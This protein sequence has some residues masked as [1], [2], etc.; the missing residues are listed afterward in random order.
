MSFGNANIG[1]SVNLA[2]T[3]ASDGTDADTVTGGVQANTDSFAN[4]DEVQGSAF[5]DT[6]VGGGQSKSFSGQLSETFRG[7]AGNDSVDGSAGED[8]VDYR[9]STGAANVTLGNGTLGGSA[10]D[11]QGGTDTL[12]NVEAVRG[13]AF[14]DTLTGGGTHNTGT[15]YDYEVFEGME[16]NDII[17]GG[18]GFDI[19]VYGASDGGVIVNLSNLDQTVG[20]LIVQAGTALDGFGTKDTLLGVEQVIGSDYA[21]TIF[22]SNSLTDR[23]AFRGGAGNDLIFGGGGNDGAFYNGSPNAVYVNLG[24][25]FANDG[26]GDVDTLVDIEAARGSIFNDTLLGGGS[27]NESFEGIQGND[28]IDARRSVTRSASFAPR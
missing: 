28:S 22:G 23:E 9:F 6:L 27:G 16:G 1:V 25:G 14:A 2:G 21:D 4:I 19:A 7:T 13:S 11:G 15:I 3:T 10:S 24:G 20:A 5:N 18:T 17:S 12:R 8:R 26:Y